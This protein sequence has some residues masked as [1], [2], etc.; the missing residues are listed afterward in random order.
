MNRKLKFDLDVETNALLCANPEEFYSKA[1]LTQEDIANNFRTLPGIKS[2][3]K[4]ANVTF[5]AILQA[6]TCNFN[7]PNDSLDAVDIDVCPLS[8]MAQLCQ[9][10]LEQSFLALQMSKGSNGD[11]TVASF[12]AYYWN[13][14]AMQIGQDI[15]LLRWQGDVESE[16]TLLSLCNGYIK[17]L[18]GDVNIAAGLYAGAVDSTNVLATLETVLNAAPSTIVRKKADLRFYVSTNVAQAYELAA[19]SGNTMTYVTLPLGLTFLGINVV[20][21]EGMADNTIVLTLKNNLIYAFDAE[22]DDK[23]LKAVNLSDSVA[24]PY[25]RTRANMKVGFHYVNPA[26]IV[27]YNVCFD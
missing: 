27:V 6:S 16:D 8:A 26:E 22:G 23:A 18:C 1:Y 7:A 19:A 13:E 3:T 15:E 12:M 2:K 4:L 11:F 10:D 21:C 5:G 9:F 25:L 24:E 20:V 17:Q 14:M